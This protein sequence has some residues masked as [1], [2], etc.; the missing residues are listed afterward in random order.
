MFLEFLIWLFW[1][2]YNLWQESIDSSRVGA[3][4]LED[5]ARKFWKGCAMFMTC[6]VIIPLALVAAVWFYLSIR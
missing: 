5:D 6:L 3:S 4:P 2:P 1:L